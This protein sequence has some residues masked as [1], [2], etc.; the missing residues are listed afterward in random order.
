MKFE[1]ETDAEAA[2]ELAQYA[3]GV[4]PKDYQVEE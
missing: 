2:A 4:V 3:H 1:D